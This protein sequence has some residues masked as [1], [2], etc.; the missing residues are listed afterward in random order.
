[1]RCVYSK[2]NRAVY[3]NYPKQKIYQ[4]VVIYTFRTAKLETLRNYGSTL[5]RNTNVAVSV[6]LV[7]LL[8]CLF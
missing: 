6:L 8:S 4:A 5:N 7:L 2:G 1:M 3:P